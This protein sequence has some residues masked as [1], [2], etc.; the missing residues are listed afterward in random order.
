MIAFESRLS[1]NGGGGGGGGSS[2]SD[3][4]NPGGRGGTGGGLLYLQKILA[5]GEIIFEI[6]V[7]GYMFWVWQSRTVHSSRKHACSK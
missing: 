7:L 5:E 2:F 4:R 6:L 1:Y 3:D